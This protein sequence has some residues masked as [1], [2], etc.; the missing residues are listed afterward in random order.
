MSRSGAERRW[1]PW[2]GK[3]DKLAL[4]WSCFV[5]HHSYPT[6][7]KSFE[8]IAA[9]RVHLLTTWAESYW[10]HMRSLA[11]D[12][13]PQLPALDERLLASRRAQARDLS[14]LFL[15]MR[16]AT[17]SCRPPP[18]RYAP[19]PTRSAMPPIASKNWSAS[20]RRMQQLIAVNFQW[21]HGRAPCFNLPVILRSP[22]ARMIQ[23]PPSYYSSR[24]HICDRSDGRFHDHADSQRQNSYH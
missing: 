22:A 23:C 10:A 2:F 13:A 17:P 5:N 21:A 8:G 24:R 19:V 7:E 1:L 16:A 3:N 12:L 11:E 6:I 9:T 14:E 4:G 15:S 18:S 20:S